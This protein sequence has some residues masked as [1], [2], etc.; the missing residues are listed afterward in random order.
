MYPTHTHAPQQ[1]ADDYGIKQQCLAI[2]MHL[3]SD[4]DRGLVEP[5]AGVVVESCW[6]LMQ[7]TLPLM[8][9]HEVGV[10]VVV[11][12]QSSTLCGGFAA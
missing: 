5:Y 8:V 12:P 9:K 11:L 6:H 4:L 2:A 3:L 10:R 7:H 1:D